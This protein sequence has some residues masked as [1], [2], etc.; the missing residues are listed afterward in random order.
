MQQE[1]GLLRNENSKE[2]LYPAFQKLYSSLNSLEKFQKGNDF[3]DNISSLDNFFSEYR[4]ITFSLQKS[5]AHSQLLGVYEELRN[6]YLANDVCKW[7]LAKRNEV[8]HEHPFD[9]EKKIQVHVY[10]T[11][12]TLTLLE[13]TFTVENDVE[14][15]TLIDSLKESL[16]SINPVEVMFSAEFSFYERDHQEELYDKFIEGIDHMKLFMKSLKDIIHEPSPLSDELEKKIDKLT[17]YKVSKNMLFIDDYIFYCKTNQFERASRAEMGVIT[18]NP[19]IPTLAL[20]KLFP[21]SDDLFEQFVLMHL[22]TFKM[23]EKLMPTCFIVYA[24]QTMRMTSFESSIKTT[25]YRKF[26][27]IAE[28]IEPGGIVQVLYVGEMYNYKNFQEITNLESRERIKHSNYES[29]VF[30]MLSK[31]L[32]FKSY[33]F[34]SD[35]IQDME[36]ITQTLVKDTNSIKNLGFFNSIEY[37]FRGLRCK[38]AI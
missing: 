2:L 11:E 29:L 35:K 20:E 30:F 19:R 38:P 37:A 25:T 22:M 4:S 32:S 10:S 15:S 24:D 6:K 36:Y 28:E 8:L 27:E 5:L 16:L 33:S 1:S 34:D 9:L 12:M 14:Y 21:E 13:L 17:F 31:D 7:F 3:F 18:D 26:H 23:Q